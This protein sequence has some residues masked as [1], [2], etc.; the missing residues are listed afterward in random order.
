MSFIRENLWRALALALGAIAL[1]LAGWVAVLLVQI[2]GAPILRPI[3]RPIFGEGLK[4]ALA[5]CRA[6]M[7]GLLRAQAEA[8]ALQAAVNEDEERRWAANATRS[9]AYHAQDLERAAV[10]GRDY[11]DRYR[12]AAGG[13]RATGDRSEAGK[14]PA[15]AASD[16][17]GV[18]EAVPTDPLVAVAS[19]DLQACTAAVTYAVAAHN[20]AQTLPRPEDATVPAR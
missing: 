12:I 8:E 6:D 7:A 4:P 1:A 16:S 9:D 13:V 19:P 11:A 5:T 18:S 10:A 3:F 14:T 17:A 15:A 20:W 2:H